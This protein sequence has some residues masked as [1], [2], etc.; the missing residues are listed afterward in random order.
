MIRNPSWTMLESVLP[1]GSWAGR[2]CVCVASGPSMMGFDYTKLKGWL[3]IGVNREFE[4]FDPTILVWSDTNFYRWLMKGEYGP[5]ALKRFREFRG[6][7]AWVLSCELDI[8]PGIYALPMC[9]DYVYSLHNFSMDLS[10]GVCQGN[11]TGYAALNLAFLLGA[12]P[13]YLLGYD[14]GS[15]VPGRTHHHSGHPSK[16]EPSVFEGFAKIYKTA[17]RCIGDP[18]RVVNLNPGSNLKAFKFQKREEVFG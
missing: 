16:H 2:P 7:K 18:D 13:I 5:E 6:F 8:D 15:K 3:S 14:M 1:A 4:F 17:A 9:R 10:E 11:N 12:S